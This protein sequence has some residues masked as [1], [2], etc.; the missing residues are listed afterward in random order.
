M[1]ND[2]TIRDIRRTYYQQILNRVYT[3]QYPGGIRAFC[4]DYVAVYQGLDKLQLPV[5]EEEK[6]ANFTL[7]AWTPE[8][9]E[10]ISHLRMHCHTLQEITQQ[11]YA[12]SLKV[13]YYNATIAARR[14][15][16]TVQDPLSVLSIQENN[17]H[18]V[19]RINAAIQPKENKFTPYTIPK[20]AWALMDNTMRYKYLMAR[21][22]ELGVPPP[23]PFKGITD[24]ET[25]IVPAP[26]SLPQQYEKR[27]QLLLMDQNETNDDNEQS[28]SQDV[29]FTEDDVNDDEYED[30]I[31][32]FL[33]DTYNSLTTRKLHLTTT[34]RAHT[35][36]LNVR[37][38][39]F[40]TY[41]DDMFLAVSDS[42][43]DTCLYGRG[44][45]LVAATNRTANVISFDPTEAKKFGLTIGSHCTMTCLQDGSWVMIT[46][47][48]I[49]S[50]PS[51]DTSLLSE[52][53]LREYGCLVDSVSRRH[54]LT[55]TTMGTQRLVSPYDKQFPLNIHAALAVLPHRRPTQ[56]EIDTFYPTAI[57][58]TSDTVWNPHTLYDETVSLD[59]ATQ[60]NPTVTGNLGS[61]YRY[62]SKST[63]RVIHLFPALAF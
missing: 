5:L 12:D 30:V 9:K 45:V 11:V 53:Q 17:P 47:H 33:L 32:G 52:T 3:A 7:H 48:E 41:P 44:W 51:S 26:T 54:R 42:G 23:K 55:T 43:A 56:D 20:A 15:N 2:P 62:T 4:N 13:D 10:L 34:H 19:A 25:L 16:L 49:V 59:M 31:A 37:A 22:A 14:A 21:N 46:I 60:F 1:V 50:N 28:V 24:S 18:P 29:T 61:S 6:I 58:L 27:A 35:S 63:S 38:N 36:Y 57:V 40:A 8:N 39:N